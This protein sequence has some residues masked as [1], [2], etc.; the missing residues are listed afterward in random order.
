V[1][2]QPAEDDY[3]ESP[4]ARILFRRPAE[5]IPLPQRRSRRQNPPEQDADQPAQTVAS[6]SGPNSGTRITLSD[7][8]GDWESVTTVWTDAPEPLHAMVGRVTDARTGG[9]PTDIALACWAVLVLIPRGL[10]HL[11]S[12]VLSHPLRLVVAAALAAVFLATL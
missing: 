8:P 10:L 7:I 11:A 9:T 12:W 5:V 6:D 1:S 4:P 2:A 3:V